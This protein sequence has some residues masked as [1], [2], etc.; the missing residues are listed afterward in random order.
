TDTNNPTGYTQVL[1]EHVGGSS[2]PS[3]SY[4]MGL[5]VVAQTNASGATSYLMVDAQ[6]STRQLTDSS[7]TITARFAFDAYGNLLYVTVGVL[8]QP[9]K[10]IL[11]TGQ[12]FDPVLLQ[13]YL[14]ARFYASAVGRFTQM[15]GKPGRIENPQTL[16]RFAYVKSDPIN[17]IDPSGHEFWSALGTLIV[18]TVRA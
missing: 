3:M 5:S 13:Y 4:I 6:G 1:E 17:F 8:N 18:Q 7:G 16:N 15:D 2:A 11:Y 10:K 9:A 14:R 12:Q